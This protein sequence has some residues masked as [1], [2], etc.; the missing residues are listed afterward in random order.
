LAFIPSALIPVFLGSS[1]LNALALLRQTIG[2]DGNGYEHYG[3]YHGSVPMNRSK[4]DA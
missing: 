1:H 3:P 2:S 4:G